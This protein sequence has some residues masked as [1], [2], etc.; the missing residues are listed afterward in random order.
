MN[1]VVVACLQHIVYLN[2]VLYS[3]CLRKEYSYNGIIDNIPVCQIIYFALVYFI[4]FYFITI[5]DIVMASSAKKRQYD[6]SY[7]QYGFTAIDKNGCEFP[8]CH[9]PQGF[10]SGVYEAS[11][12]QTPSKQLS[13]KC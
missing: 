11:L 4:L 10:I 5:S 3:C 6:E 7:I 9:M 2:E 8:V 12:S 1:I 13:S